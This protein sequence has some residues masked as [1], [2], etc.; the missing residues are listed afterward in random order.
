MDRECG[1]E[2]VNGLA[3][4]PLPPGAYFGGAFTTW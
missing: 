1:P 3:A 4:A 2:G